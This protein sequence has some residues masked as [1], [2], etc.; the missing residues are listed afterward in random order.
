MV[1]PM[2][3]RQKIAHLGKPDVRWLSELPGLITEL[4]QLWPIIVCRPGRAS[5]AGS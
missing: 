2:A 3:V 5:A 1:L 4:E